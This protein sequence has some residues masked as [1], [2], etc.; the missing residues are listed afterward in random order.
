MIEERIVLYPP[1]QVKFI[2]KLSFMFGVMCI[3][4]TEFLALREPQWFTMV[5]ISITFLYST[6]TSGSLW[7]LL[8]VLHYGIFFALYRPSPFHVHCST[9][10]V[11]FLHYNEHHLLRFPSSTPPSWPSFWCT[12]HPSFQ[13]LP[14]ILPAIEITAVCQVPGL[15]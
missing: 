4:L 8:S 12:G 14:N 6:K 15:L 5:N 11:S 9:T 1:L 2:D 3:V 10:M 7:Y 13:P